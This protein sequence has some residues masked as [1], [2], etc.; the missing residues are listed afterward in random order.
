MPSMTRDD[1]EAVF[2]S[3]GVSFPLFE[4]EVPN[5]YPIPFLYGWDTVPLNADNVAPPVRTFLDALKKRPPVSLYVG[6][7]FCKTKCA[8]CVYRITHGKNNQTADKRAYLESLAKELAVYQAEG[9][10]F[11]E[12]RQLYIGGGT[13]SILEPEEVRQLFTSLA[14]V[15]NLSSL[16]SSCFELEPETTKRDLL[17]ELKHQGVNRV[18]MG[19]QDLDDD[20]LRAQG[21][22]SRVSHFNSAIDLLNE[23]GFYYNLDLIYGL[24]GQ[25]H[26]RWLEALNMLTEERRV[27]EIT[28]YRLRCGSESNDG[29]AFPD[30]DTLAARI[31][32][33]HLFARACDQLR[34]N[35]RYT[36]VRPCHWVAE[37]FLEQWKAYKFAPM[38]DLRSDAEDKQAPAQLGIGANAISHAAEVIVRNPDFSDYQSYWDDKQ[39]SAEQ[40]PKF[41]TYYQLTED[42]RTARTILLNLEH[43]F[44]VSLKAIPQ[45]CKDLREFIQSSSDLLEPALEEDEYALTERGLVFYDY[46]ELYFA[47]EITKY[48]KRVDFSTPHGAEWATEILA[49]VLGD[50]KRERNDE[51]LVC[52]EF[53]AGVGA[54]SI[55]V[56][57]C[58]REQKRSAR[59]YAL[60]CDAGK[61]EYYW[62]VLRRSL[63]LEPKDVPGSF[64]NP[65]PLE[66]I[67]EDLRVYLVERNIDTNF[68]FAKADEQSIIP[69]IVDIFFMPSFLNHIVF[70]KQ[71]LEFAWK[72]LKPGGWI[73]LGYPGRAW[74]PMLLGPVVHYD[75]GVPRHEDVYGEIFRTWYRTFHSWHAFFDR[76]IG[77]WPSSVPAGDVEVLDYALRSPSMETI[78]QLLCEGDFSATLELKKEDKAADYA[79]QEALR[80]HVRPV[81]RKFAHPNNSQDFHYTFQLLQKPRDHEEGPLPE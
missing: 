69:D 12:V 42:D 77:D 19:V 37:D 40:S 72:R 41:A 76:P 61:L 54:L 39:E 24:P 20:V 60:D 52:V 7:P 16:S 5:T 13:P 30:T 80:S 68:L 62:H 66:I 44:R 26:D 75:A 14:R 33:K 79:E 48:R 27:P 57:S 43:S 47:H 38:S 64:S 70:K 65:S 63:D 32:Q 21:R 53:G 58:L 22:G 56:I 9:I 10:V 35:K 4:D 59:W 11:S 25:N 36:R 34:A 2:S 73:I 81:F 71:C 49:K 45:Y 23:I 6:I 15:I 46:L 51:T 18:S 1:V 31:D 29:E 74:A 8:F 67:C 50:D 17:E 78:Y 55:P 28:L 3:I